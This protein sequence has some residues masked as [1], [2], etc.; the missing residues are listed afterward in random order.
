MR[1][2][3]PQF[4]QVR[5]LSA[6]LLTLA[7]AGCSYAPLPTAAHPTS[8]ATTSAA[9]SAAGTVL[10]DIDGQ[11]CCVAADPAGP[12]VVAGIGTTY[13]G[14]DTAFISWMVPHF[15]VASQLAELAPTRAESA[16]VK[17]LASTVDAAMSPNYLK[18]SAMAK[19]WGQP[20]PSTDPSAAS[21]HDHGGDDSSGADNAASLTKLSG[22][23]F[24]RKYLQVLIAD[25]RAALAIAN[26]TVANCTNPQAKSLARELAK[27]NAAQIAEA[28]R[29]LRNGA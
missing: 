13:N 24:D 29:L 2:P 16:E 3:R 1:Q 6:A 11:I 27:A 14:W 23:K 28:Q 22:T 18:M 4:R 5:T 10:P 8:V 25:D 9:A 21:G 12:T 19:A 15:A 26:S 20:V 7:L 17:T